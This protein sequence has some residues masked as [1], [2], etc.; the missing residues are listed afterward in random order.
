MP[1]DRDLADHGS[2][3]VR[4]VLTC[5]VQEMV[6]ERECPGPRTCQQYRGPSAIPCDLA[7]VKHEDAAALHPSQARGIPERRLVRLQGRYGP[8]DTDRLSADREKQE[9]GAFLGGD[10]R[11]VLA[12]DGSRDSCPDQERAEQGDAEGSTEH[13]RLRERGGRANGV[14]PGGGASSEAL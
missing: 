3:L 13:V 9:Q 11:P 8:C 14:A 4:D 10:G 1:P 2:E 5:L 12:P 6:G 7:P